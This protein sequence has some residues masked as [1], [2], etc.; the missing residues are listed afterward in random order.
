M[1][2]NYKK[3]F[4]IGFLDAIKLGFNHLEGYCFDLYYRTDTQSRI[5]LGDLHIDDE[6]KKIRNKI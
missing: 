4:R 6:N 1:L 2:K 3:I 5:A